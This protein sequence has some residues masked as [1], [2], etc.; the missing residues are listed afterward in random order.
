[1]RYVAPPD[2]TPLADAAGATPHPAGN[3]AG[4]LGTTAAP[5]FT[6]VH[7]DAEVTT[8]ASGAGVLY[9]TGRLAIRG[10]LEFTGVVAAAAGVDVAA[11][12]HLAVCGAVWAGGVPAL[13]VR[14]QGA[15]RSS[16]AAITAASRVAPLPARAAVIAARELFSRVY[17]TRIG[18]NHG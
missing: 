7:G 10:R 15:V 4:T 5:R 12:G 8:V 17:P 16:A 11:S 14:G 13:A 18:G 2:L 9:V 6:V 3:L 1:V